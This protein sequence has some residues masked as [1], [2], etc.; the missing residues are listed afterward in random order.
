MYKARA[1]CSSSRLQLIAVFLTADRTTVQVSTRESELEEA[2]AKRRLR[3][4]LGVSTPASA[5][6]DPT[7]IAAG[8]TQGAEDGE[9][10]REPQGHRSSLNDDDDR[11]LA[12][13]GKQDKYG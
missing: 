12:G 9:G 5:H 4:L 11:F 13:V 1:R 6:G 3:R 8:T 2:G 10:S 7:S